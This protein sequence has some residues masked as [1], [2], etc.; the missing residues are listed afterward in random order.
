MAKRKTKEEFTKEVYDL[1]GEEYTFLDEYKTSKDNLLFKHN[2]CGYVG[3]I[4]PD[5]FLRGTRCSKC[6]FGKMG[7]SRRKTTEQ[8][9]NEVYSVVGE[10]Y[11]VL[12]EYQTNDT[13]ILMRHNICGLEWEPR[14]SLF[15]KCGKRCPRCSKVY[16]RTQKDFEDDIYRLV[17]DEYIFQEPYKTVGDKIKVLHKDC[18][19]TYEV[20]PTHFLAGSR[21]PQC[22]FSRGERKV[23]EAL[24]KNGVEYQREYVIGGLLRMDFRL[25]ELRAFIEYDGIQHYE[26]VEFWG[27]EEA[28]ESLQFR[29]SV[30]D[31]FCGMQGIPLLRIPYWDFDNIPEI[32]ENFINEVKTKREAELIGE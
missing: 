13:N 21:C 1:V 3:Y 12:G 9:K 15:T 28:L 22:R 17:G 23:K 14:P 11:T 26:P 6:S 16:K 4:N 5:N 8:F 10:E 32:V 31:S 30:K 29:D 27:G 24:E 19:N 18:G 20:K 7:K 25:T 2:K